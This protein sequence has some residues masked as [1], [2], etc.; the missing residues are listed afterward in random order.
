MLL[1]LFKHFFLKKLLDIA[2]VKNNALIG[3]EIAVA[4]SR[5]R[6]QCNKG[7]ICISSFIDWYINEMRRGTLEICKQY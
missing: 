5:L 2:L 6:E 3:S 4:L 7:K 1:D